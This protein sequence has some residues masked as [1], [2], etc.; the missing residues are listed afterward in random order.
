MS[1]SFAA[2]CKESGESAVLSWSLLSFY[3][4]HRSERLTVLIVSYDPLFFAQLLPAAR[5]RAVR[6]ARRTQEIV[7][8]GLQLAFAQ[9]S[10]VATGR[11][12]L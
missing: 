6:P 4:P 9:C 3:L 11:V 7:Q 2:A 8:R 12:I 5:L 10:G 1:L